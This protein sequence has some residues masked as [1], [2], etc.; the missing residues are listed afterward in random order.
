M[1]V[2]PA[3]SISI[4]QSLTPPVPAKNNTADSSQPFDRQFATAITTATQ[5]AASSSAPAQ[6]FPELK[7]VTILPWGQSIAYSSSAS[8]TK[9]AEASTSVL[10]IAPFVPPSIGT[11]ATVPASTPASTP[12]AASTPPVTTKPVPAAL[13]ASQQAINALSAILSGYGIDPASLGLSYSEQLVAGPTGTYSNNMISA[14]FPSGKSQDYNAELTLKNPT[15][16]AVEIMAMLGR[17]IVA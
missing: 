14:K 8:A 3:T 4:F 6:S 2:P 1:V 5:T 11:T 15:V 13:P 10:P 9:P 12:V 7:T 16:A 17:R